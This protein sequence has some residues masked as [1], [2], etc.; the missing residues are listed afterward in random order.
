M[1]G[2][3]QTLRAISVR[4]SEVGDYMTVAE[5]FETRYKVKCAFTSHFW[6]A[7]GVSLPGN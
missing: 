4:G 7:H 3:H 2:F 1:A 5:Y 6:Q